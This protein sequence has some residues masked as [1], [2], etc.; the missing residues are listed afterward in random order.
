MARPVR[1]GVYGQSSKRWP[2]AALSH[3]VPEQ[4]APS[5][6]ALRLS[7]AWGAWGTSGG[8]YTPFFGA[9]LAYKGM[10]PVEIGT[11]LSAGMLLR[12]IVPPVTGIIADAR[13]EDR[14]STRLNSSH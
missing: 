1:N 4:T 6:I 13:N 11:L 2:S 9:W 14:K 8:I 12:V 5:P 10:N 3:S 7:V